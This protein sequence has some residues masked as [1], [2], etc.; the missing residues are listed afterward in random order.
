MF[1]PRAWSEGAADG[2]REGKLADYL[3]AAVGQVLRMPADAVPRD[4][5]LTDLGLD[6]LMGIELRNR[7][8]LDLGV[9]PPITQV[10][11]APS[12]S[13]LAATLGELLGE[14]GAD[15]GVAARLAT[16]DSLLREIEALSDDEARRRL[17][18]A[19]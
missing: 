11:S 12:V 1:D 4:R 8:R 18:E 3:A 19:D 16:D 13:A 6:S 5:A 7:L 14:A 9:S 17:G 10:L 2:D 15:A